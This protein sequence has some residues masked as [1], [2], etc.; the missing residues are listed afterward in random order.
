M[1][2]CIEARSVLLGY[3]AKVVATRLDLCIDKPEM[4]SIIGPNGSGKSTLLK[5]LCRLLP[6]KTG[7]VLLDGKDIHRMPPNE[8][9]RIM[10]VLPQSV[11]APSDITVHDLVSYGRSP[12][13]SMFAT[14]S[15]IDKSQV[16][17]A[18]IATGMTEFVHR[19][20]DTL[21]GGERQRAWLAMALAQQPQILMLDEPTTYLDIF[22]QLELMKLVQRLHQERQITVVMVLHDLNHAARFSQRVVAVKAGKVFADGAVNEV[23]TANTLK[24]LYGVETTVMT[25]KQGGDEHL[26]CFPHD[27]CLSCGA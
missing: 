23:F 9:A 25:V 24:Q 21:S 10:A 2:H 20:L 8:V 18:I 4:V 11:Q 3:G 5:A 22:H 7:S 27:I 6:P 26:V 17:D 1:S 15:E 14:V 16:M 13:Q 19:R 12:H